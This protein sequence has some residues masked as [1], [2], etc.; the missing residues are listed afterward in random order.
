V[1][2]HRFAILAVAAFASVKAQTVTVTPPGVSGLQLIGS[3]SPEFQRAL[4]AVISQPLAPQFAAYIPFMVV[5]KNGSAQALAGYGFW[6]AIDPVPNRR[7]GG[8]GNGESF[9]SY[10]DG[11]LQPGASV[12]AMP[13]MILRHAPGQE[14]LDAMERKLRIVSGLQRA[15]V[16]E[17]L[18][19]WAVL[20][21]GQFVGPDV[22]GEFPEIA[23][24][25]SGWRPVAVSV[26]SQLAN[27]VPFETILAGLQ[28]IGDQPVSG[29]S[30]TSRDWTAQA[31]AD[32]ARHL[33][34]LYQRSGAEAVR[35]LVNQ[36]LQTPEI[37]VYR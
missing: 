3:Q 13:G 2:L 28:Q 10:K 1:R 36:Q 17:V 32:E 26:Q 7:T 23:G 30:K 34:K 27:G 12:L 19:N 9:P 5:L 11:F 4:A 33:V 16:V 6:W 37:V 29:N 25:F 20:A 18:L 35:T 21:S 22:R 24:E 15:K 31:G 8:N 14:A